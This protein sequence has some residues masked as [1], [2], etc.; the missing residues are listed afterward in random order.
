MRPIALE[1]FSGD[2]MSAT[3]AC[4]VPM[5]PPEM[6]SMILPTNSI[7]SEWPMPMIVKPRAVPSVLMMSTGRRPKRSDIWPK[8]GAAKNWMS[9][10]MPKSQPISHGVAPNRS[11]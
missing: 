2:V 7:V 5:L 8:T 6:P 11:A 9:E 4:A 1:R 3:Y 10:K